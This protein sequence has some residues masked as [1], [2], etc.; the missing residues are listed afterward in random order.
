MCW[1]N[2]DNFY[3]NVRYYIQ[4]KSTDQL[5]GKPYDLEDEVGCFPFFTNGQMQKTTTWGG[6]NITDTHSP[7]SPCG[8]IGNSFNL[9]S[10]NILQ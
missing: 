2:V 8:A 10:C 5:A 7:A 9:F 4:S 1:V 3:Q 6:R